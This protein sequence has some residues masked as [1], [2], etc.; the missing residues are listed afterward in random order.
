MKL[1]IIKEPVGSVPFA[2]KVGKENKTGK[3]CFKAVPLYIPPCPLTEEEKEIRSQG[4]RNIKVGAVFNDPGGYS[5]L[6]AL[7]P[8]IIVALD[9]IIGE[10]WHKNSVLEGN[11]LVLQG[12]SYLDDL[13]DVK[14]ILTSITY[15]FI[16]DEEEQ[17]QIEVPTDLRRGFNFMF[18]LEEEELSSVEVIETDPNYYKH[19]IFEA[20]DDIT[21]QETQDV[22]IIS[23]RRH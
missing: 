18:G 19:R 11:F 7:F 15:S 13:G 12:F 5:A 20:M 22:H 21:F 2:F 3:P 8:D 10:D 23:Q 16:T 6:S 14:T 17:E 4:M 9:D 1:D